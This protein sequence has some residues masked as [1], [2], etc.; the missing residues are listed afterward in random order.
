[1]SVHILCGAHNALYKIPQ[2]KGSELSYFFRYG[3]SGQ[4]VDQ[5]CS[6]L[7]LFFFSFSQ[8]ADRQPDDVA[9]RLTDPS[10]A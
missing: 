2:E 5:K 10:L 6:V 9:G 3:V 1:M 8:F 4:I 7:F